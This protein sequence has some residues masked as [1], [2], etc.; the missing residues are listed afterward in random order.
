[1]WV[2]GSVRT[3]SC[4]VG[5]IGFVIAGCAIA[6]MDDGRMIEMQAGDVFSIPPGHDS[7]VVGEKPYDSIHLIGA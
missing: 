6:A 2:L 5:H 7:W 3:N 4:S 1:M